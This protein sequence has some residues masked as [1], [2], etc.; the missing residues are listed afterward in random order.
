[1]KLFFFLLVTLSTASTALA[2]ECPEIMQSE[3][4][5][6]SQSFFAIGT[7]LEVLVSGQHVGQLEQRLFE[8]K[9][10]LELLNAD[11][12]VVARATKSYF[13]RDAKIEVVDCA[14]K[15]VGSIRFDIF[16]SDYAFHSSYSIYDH[17]GAIRAQSKTLDRY[18]TDIP[19]YGVDGE[20]VAN[21]SKFTDQYFTTHWQ[22][23]YDSGLIDKRLLFFAAADRTIDRKKRK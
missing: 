9:K 1:M 17:N 13:D 19:L 22:I 3:R 20:A 2:D 12:F 4:Y 23:T 7:D 5:S 21:L 14:G 15:S 16:V 18:S 6:M 8:T 11:G 10:T